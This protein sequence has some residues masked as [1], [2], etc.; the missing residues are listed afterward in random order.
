M[1]RILLQEVAA[2]ASVGLFVAMVGVWAGVFT[3]V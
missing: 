2:L 1:I 3:G